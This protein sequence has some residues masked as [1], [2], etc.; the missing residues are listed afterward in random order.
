MFV[1]DDWFVVVENV[2]KVILSFIFIRGKLISWKV[3][4]E[5]GKLNYVVD[6][7]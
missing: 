6:F 4:G 1:I 7:Y 3:M 5:L 2:L